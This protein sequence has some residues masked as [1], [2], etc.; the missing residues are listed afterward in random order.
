MTM[1]RNAIK[2]RMKE[3]NLKPCHI[4]EM[5]KDRIPRQTIYDFLT[6]KKNDKSWRDTRTEVASALLEVLGLE[7]VKIRNLKESDNNMSKKFQFRK[8]VDLNKV[9]KLCKIAIKIGRGVMVSRKILQQ[10]DSNELN[11][12][13]SIQLSKW[14]N[15]KPDLLVQPIFEYISIELFGYPLKRID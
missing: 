9:T 12:A 6:E 2:E 4:Y 1:I 13:T 10:L 3:L 7:I 15:P 11:E 5:L 8:D 14:V